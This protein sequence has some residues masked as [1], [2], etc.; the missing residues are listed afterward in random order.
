MARVIDETKLVRVHEAAMELIVEKGYAGAS[1]SLIAKKADVSEGYLYRFYKGKEQLVNSLLDN[2][3]KEVSEILDTYFDKHESAITIMEG[4]LSA[5]CKIAEKKPVQIKFIFVMLSSYNF[6]A[7]E[8][9]KNNMIETLN[10]LLIIGQKQNVIDE[11]V[12]VDHFFTMLIIYPIQFINF[13][14]KQFLRK[15]TF[16]RKD[17]KSLIEFVTETLK[18]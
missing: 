13:R 11:N 9:I 6:T 5:I 15:G 1:I 18:K 2:T 3:L 17:K 7:S 16:S 8:D 4:L 12:S 14:L 10:K